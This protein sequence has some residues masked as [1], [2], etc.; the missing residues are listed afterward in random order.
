MIKKM[1]V[2]GLG[3]FGQSLCSELVEQ[4]AEV[5]AIDI[6]E[7]AVSRVAD[8]VS[9][10]VIADTTDLH[11]AQELDLANYDRVLVSISED[12][13]VSIL[14]TLVL[15]EIGVKDLWVKSQ[16]PMHRKILWKIGADHV[17][18]PERE[19]GR[20]VAHQMLADSLLDYFDLNNGLA[21]YELT[22]PRSLL[23]KP[24][25]KLAIPDEITVLGLNRGDQIMSNV[26][27]DLTLIEGDILFIAGLKT[28]LQKFV[29]CL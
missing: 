10:A 25:A 6:D 18:N 9:Q 19:M 21:I 5:L 4:G 17:V 7:A 3:R 26:S 27:R 13:H 20:R 11:V 22:L 28:R 29:Q 23:N 2:I 8:F 12:I 16:N 24:L 14:V 15:K 1:A